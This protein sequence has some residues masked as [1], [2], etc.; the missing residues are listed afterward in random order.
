M[1]EKFKYHL[2][3]S[4]VDFPIG[5]VIV[6][7]PIECENAF[8]VHQMVL[9]TSRITI[10]KLQLANRKIQPIVKF[11]ISHEPGASPGSILHHP[12]TRGG[13]GWSWG[14]CGCHKDPCQTELQF[15]RVPRMGGIKLQLLCG[16]RIE[17]AVGS[18]PYPG[19]SGFPIVSPVRDRPLPGFPI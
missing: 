8:F 16:V 2:A 17:L 18:L 5:L 1:A 3:F 7:L 11:T 4:I 14:R 13:V 9:L 12:G 19:K 6:I 10:E 15:C